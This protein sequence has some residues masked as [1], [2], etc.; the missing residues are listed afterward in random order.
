MIGFV[1]RTTW[2]SSKNWQ[3]NRFHQNAVQ[4]FAK[5]WNEIRKDKGNR[6]DRRIPKL[7]QY[8]IDALENAKFQ[9][10]EVDA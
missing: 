10:V 7:A 3:G 6:K 2:T 1:S 8:S 5:V 4:S 9:N